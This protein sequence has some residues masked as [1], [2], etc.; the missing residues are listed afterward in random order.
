MCGRYTLTANDHRRLG[1]RF[2]AAVV[3][4]AALE[5]FNVAPTEEALAIVV[6]KTGVR[7]AHQMRWSLVPGYAK[8]LKG[9][10]MFNARA[11]TITIKAPFSK[12][13]ASQRSRCLI[14]ADGF[15]EWLRPEDRKAPRVPFR[16][17]VDG[18]EPF[19][20]AGLWTWSKPAGEWLASATILTCRPNAA[21]A[22][23]HDRMPVILPGPE[24]EAAWLSD[25][26][27][28]DEAQALCVPLDAGRM[29][30]APANPRMNKSGLEDEGPDLLSAP[31]P[32]A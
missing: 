30:A 24:A 13:V 18:G 17:T 11:E 19:A 27:S 14:V 23:L 10:P 12:L 32:A 8:D 7:E 26:L 25:G 15:Y 6:G 28:A 20:F 22:R 9:P 29:Q 2:G 31:A 16:F 1:E 21:V 3:P 4:G 5:R